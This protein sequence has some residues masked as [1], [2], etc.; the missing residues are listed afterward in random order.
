MSYTEILIWLQ[1]IDWIREVIGTIAI[2]CGFIAKWQLGNG[3][4]VGWLWGF[5]GSFFWLIFSARIE[6]PTGF[7]NNLVFLCLAV[8]GYRIWT[9]RGVGETAK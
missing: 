5:A 8:R 1:G 2:I 6:S 9:S 4:K 7:L 3:K